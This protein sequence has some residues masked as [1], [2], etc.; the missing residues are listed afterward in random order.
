[1]HACGWQQACFCPSG[2]SRI[3]CRVNLQI[4]TG[5]E[6]P[7]RTKLSGAVSISSWDLNLLRWYQI[8]PQL[9]R[10]KGLIP[11]SP[12]TSAPKPTP[13]KRSCSGYTAAKPAKG[14]Q[15]ALLSPEGG[16]SLA[17]A[18]MLAYIHAYSCSVT[19]QREPSLSS[20]HSP[21]VS[22]DRQCNNTFYWVNTSAGKQKLFLSSG[23][24][25]RVTYVSVQAGIL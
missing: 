13:G 11:P 23:D 17:L 1:M 9:K 10:A 6:M 21:V 2:S 16:M 3:I 22:G 20:K 5:S 19:L 12:T 8:A 24:G 7:G 25:Q 15:R 4:K 14:L 18:D